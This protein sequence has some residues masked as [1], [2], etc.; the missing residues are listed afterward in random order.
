MRR[1]PTIYTAIAP[2]ALVRPAGTSSTT[3]AV[4]VSYFFG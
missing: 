4:R 1:A 3:T 2:F